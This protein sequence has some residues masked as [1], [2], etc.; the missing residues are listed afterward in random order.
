VMDGTHSD[1]QRQSTA[2]KWVQAVPLAA[3]NLQNLL[4]TSWTSRPILYPGR[5]DGAIVDNSDEK[6][7][8]RTYTAPQLMHTFCMQGKRLEKR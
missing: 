7:D 3:L 8:R 4:S 6:T 5:R 1:Q 2:R